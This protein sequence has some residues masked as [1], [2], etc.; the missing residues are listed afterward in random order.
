MTSIKAVMCF[1]PK[2]RDFDRLLQSLIKIST[3]GEQN[4]K[5]LSY[6]DLRHKTSVSETVKF[7]TSIPQ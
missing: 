1:L 6:F 7:F 3:Y 5:P 4:S 2:V